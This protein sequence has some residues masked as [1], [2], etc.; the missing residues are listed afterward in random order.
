MVRNT[1]IVKFGVGTWIRWITDSF[2]W[3]RSTGDAAL[4]MAVE[5]ETDLS[6]I[7]NKA[8]LCNEP[9]VPYFLQIFSHNFQCEA[10]PI[11]WE[12]MLA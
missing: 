2:Q 8:L 12:I 10:A 11:I 4:S 1:K 6:A 3:L 5:L 7:F 9:Q